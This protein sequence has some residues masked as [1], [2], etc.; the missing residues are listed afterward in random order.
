MRAILKIIVAL[1]IALAAFVSPA[2]G[3]GASDLWWNSSESGWGVNVA[4]QGGTL[5]L[6]FFVYGSN[7]QP[8]WLVGPS[9]SFQS[10]GT[11]GS[12]IYSGPLY[13]TTGPGFAG[14]FNPNAVTVTQVGNVTLTY[15]TTTTASVAYSV[16]GTTVTK[17]LTRQT[18]ANNI[19]L[20]GQ[21]LGGVVLTRTGCAGAAR[22]EGL[23]NL[24]VVIT[25]STMF[26]SLIDPATGQSCTSAGTFRTDGSMT[27]I[28]NAIATC[29]NGPSGAGT[30]DAIDANTVG[31]TGRIDITYGGT[32]REV[33]T[34]AGVW[35]AE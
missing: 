33:G 13:Q 25:G 35:R 5:F 21:Y 20:A 19:F 8:L 2:H 30:V 31:M 24:K 16:N 4:E 7:G 9:T 28:P 29:S 6:T 1:A 26:L 22:F 17:S 11:G 23:M 15:L 27:S 32:C 34:F 14:A 12:K 18:W 10:T 3:A